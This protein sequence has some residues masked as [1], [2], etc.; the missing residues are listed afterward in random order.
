MRN[1]ETKIFYDHDSDMLEV[2]FEKP[3]ADERAPELS[4]NIVLFLN[5]KTGK[6]I[7]LTILDYK[8][9]LEMER[10]P[11]D[12]F[13][14]FPPSLQRDLRLLRASGPSS[15]FLEWVDEPRLKKPYVRI[16][17]PEV[18]HLLAA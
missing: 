10:I 16:L 8:R 17:S 15:N 6:P 18:R 5:P 14:K 13:R 2:L 4:F 11:L 12:N 3:I 9:L 1:R 7:N